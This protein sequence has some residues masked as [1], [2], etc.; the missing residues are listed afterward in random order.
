MIWK[1]LSGLQGSVRP[2]ARCVHGFT[3]AE[4]R[5]YVHGG[6][7]DKGVCS[8]ALCGAIGEG[9]VDDRASEHRF[10]R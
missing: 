8:E 5:L 4:G 3:S 2:A 9:T 10:L 1:L 7:G 6:S